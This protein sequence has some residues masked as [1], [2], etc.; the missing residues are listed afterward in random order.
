MLNLISYF[1]VTFSAVAAMS[2]EFE[3]EVQAREHLSQKLGDCCDLEAVMQL[4]GKMRCLESADLEV[5][6]KNQQGAKDA[7]WKTIQQKG[8][9]LSAENKQR[10]E[11][12]EPTDLLTLGL[13]KA[14]AGWEEA[15]EHAART[16]A[17]Q[18]LSQAEVES[19]YAQLIRAEESLVSQSDLHFDRPQGLSDCGLTN[20]LHI[21]HDLRF[22]LLCGSDV[23]ETLLHASLRHSALVLEFHEFAQTQHLDEEWLDFRASKV[24]PALHDLNAVYVAWFT[25]EIE[26]KGLDDALRKLKSAA[27][28]V[29]VSEKEAIEDSSDQKLLEA[30]ESGRAI[31][32]ACKQRAFCAYDVKGNV[33]AMQENVRFWGKEHVRLY[34]LLKNNRGVFGANY[35]F[36]V[37]T[38]Y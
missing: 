7:F 19:A 23:D 3:S 31:V 6:Q 10:A 17:N 32:D 34:E 30:V 35:S 36:D 16:L 1:I 25:Q 11:N 15:L 12:I 5:M 24:R 29:F 26:L 2:V 21:C 4:A 37:D 20:F 22:L 9:V 18:S 14:L 8:K 27:A 33:L 13:R 38:S 28:P